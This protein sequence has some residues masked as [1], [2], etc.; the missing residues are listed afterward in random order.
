MLDLSDV[1]RTMQW[2]LVSVEIH[3]SSHRMRQLTLCGGIKDPDGLV[4][5]TLCG[6]IKDPDGLVRAEP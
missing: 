4:R 1:R 6:G 5:L 3:Y 2:P